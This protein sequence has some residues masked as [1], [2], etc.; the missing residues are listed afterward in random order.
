VIVNTEDMILL[1][2][3]ARKDTKE[4]YE[5]NEKFRQKKQGI[6]EESIKAPMFVFSISG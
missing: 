6:F 5:K 1:P 2:R 3:I 4:K